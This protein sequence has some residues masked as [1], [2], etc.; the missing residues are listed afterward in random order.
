MNKLKKIVIVFLIVLCLWW[1]MYWLY[2][3]NS[4][5]RTKTF[6]S[7]VNSEIIISQNQQ[8]LW[9]IPMSKWKKYINYTIKNTS[10]ESV[11]LWEASTSCMC[12]SAYVISRDK[13]KSS[14]IN[15]NPPISLD[16]E[17]MPWEEITLVAIFDPNAHWPNAV[18]P[19]A[20]S[21]YIETNSTLTPTLKFDFYGTVVR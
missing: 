15:M 17:I 10:N 12:T 21:V 3:V 6:D 4:Q 1:I 13:V 20:R 5:Q 8:Y 19:I 14:L 7:W 2:V 9:E 16:M 11:L 18:G